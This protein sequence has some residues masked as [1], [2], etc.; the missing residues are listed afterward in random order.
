MSSPENSFE[1]DRYIHVDKYCTH[2]TVSYEFCANRHHTG[3]VAFN[4]SRSGSSS[5]YASFTFGHSRSRAYNLDNFVIK[6]SLARNY[7]KG[8]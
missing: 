1:M 3:Y 7:I 8:S 2:I 4:G 6:E 5:G